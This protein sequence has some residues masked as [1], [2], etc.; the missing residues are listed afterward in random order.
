MSATA[1][2]VPGR[3]TPAATPTPGTASPI[4]ALPLKVDLAGAARW[5]SGKGVTLTP[6]RQPEPEK[7]GVIEQERRR[8]QQLRERGEPDPAK[9]Q[10]ARL[11]EQFKP[12]HPKGTEK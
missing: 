7:I 6:E 3:S 10:L 11:A 5:R 4:A 12:P 1:R 2:G 9:A 8:Q